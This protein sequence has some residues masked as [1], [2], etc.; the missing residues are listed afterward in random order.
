MNHRPSAF[1]S[2]LISS[3]QTICVYLTFL[4][5]PSSS[6]MTFKRHNC[7]LYPGLYL[8]YACLGLFRCKSHGTVEKCIA[9][10]QFYLSKVRKGAK[11]EDGGE[12]VENFQTLPIYNIHNMIKGFLKN[13]SRAWG[14]GFDVR[15]NVQ[16]KKPFWHGCFLKASE[17][18]IAIW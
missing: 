3:F 10:L 8:L 13:V 12:Q 14:K 5:A 17:K 4:F 9:F 2:T 1:P 16:Q 7:S 15:D 18:S 11:S 6:L